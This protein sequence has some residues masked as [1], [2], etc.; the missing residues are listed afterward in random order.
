MN[1]FT[2]DPC[3]ACKPNTVCRTPSCGRLKSKQ[4]EPFIQKK[5][6]EPVAWMCDVL[7]I[8]ATFKRELSFEVPPPDGT[9]YSIRGMTPLYTHPAP[10]VA[11]PPDVQQPVVIVTGTRHVICQCEKCKIAAPAVAVNEQMLKALKVIVDARESWIDA[12]LQ[13]EAAIAAA[14]QGKGE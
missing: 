7:Q 12:K 11:Q 10:A 6:A 2:T 3:P 8:D 4:Q 13:A 9:Y 5:Q 1:D 14:Q